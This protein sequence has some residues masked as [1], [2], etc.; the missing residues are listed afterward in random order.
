MCVCANFL[1]LIIRRYQRL[2]PTNHTML[3][4]AN[5]KISRLGKLNTDK[6]QEYCT[7]LTE[8]QLTSLAS[9][10]K[11]HAQSQSLAYSNFTYL[12]ANGMQ[13]NL[14]EQHISHTEKRQFALSTDSSWDCRLEITFSDFV[15]RKSEHSQPTNLLKKTWVFQMIL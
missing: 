7:I 10:H 14:M 3:T 4:H 15:D 8:K 12:Y 13:C 9:T 1:A 6:N 2:L 5:I 11:T